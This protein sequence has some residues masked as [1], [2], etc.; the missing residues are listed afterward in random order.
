[1]HVNLLEITEQ[2][3]LGGN[4]CPFT[5]KRIMTETFLTLQ[6]KFSCSFYLN[7]YFL[8]TQSL[9]PHVLLVFFKASPSP[10]SQ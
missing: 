1:M 7:Q 3:F 9:T 8:P 6:F 4:A 2:C 10:A 5:D